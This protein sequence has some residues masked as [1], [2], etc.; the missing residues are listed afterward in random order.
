[1]SGEQPG[2]E[3]F[4]PVL[5]DM[6]DGWCTAMGLRFVKATLEEV[7][8]EWQ[9]GPEHLQGYGIVHGGV[10]GGVIETLASIG[11]ALH[12]LPRGQLVAGLENHTSFL[13]AVRGGLLRATARPISTGRSSQVWEAT[14]A[15]EAGRPIATGRVRLLC[16][17]AGTPLGGAPTS[18]P[19]LSGGGGGDGGA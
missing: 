1:M 18:L 11:A 16:F 14:V 19:G 3:D 13:R 9:V 4:S 12:A 17:D 5:N 15:D 7:V 6:R 8:A 10:H 2:Q